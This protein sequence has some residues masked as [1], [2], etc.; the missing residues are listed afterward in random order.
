[1]LELFFDLVSGRKSSKEIQPLDVVVAGG[2]LEV[3]SGSRRLTVLNWFAGTV[4][5][6]C[7]PC[8]LLPLCA[9]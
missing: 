7:R 6:Y 3:V 1:M 2:K 8:P 5:A 4:E 9:R